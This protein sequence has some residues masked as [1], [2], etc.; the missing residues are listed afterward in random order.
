MSEKRLPKGFRSQRV[1][2][3]RF[4]GAA[5]EEDALLG[6]PDDLG[7]SLR[8][9]CASMLCIL[10]YSHIKCKVNDFVEL[11]SGEAQASYGLREEACLQLRFLG[12]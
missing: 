11:F 10:Y 2:G 12:N 8:K 1:N 6:I 4:V 3:L 9:S 7:P 5:Q